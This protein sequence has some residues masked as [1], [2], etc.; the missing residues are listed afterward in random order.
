[1]R[2][3]Q[4]AYSIYEKALYA[5]LAG[6][7]RN[8]CEAQIGT[9]GGTPF[10]PVLPCSFPDSPCV[11]QLVGLR[12]GLLQSDGGRQD[13]TGMPLHATAADLHGNKQRDGSGDLFK[14]PL[15]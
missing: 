13:R 12:V 8:V 14:S 1:M 7:I 4:P 9:G 5:A 6:D 15:F 10:I 3:L 11:W 2:L